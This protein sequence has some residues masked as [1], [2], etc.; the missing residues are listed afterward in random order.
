MNKKQQK[1][2]D[3]SLAILQA[4]DFPRAQQN[5][6]SALT[7]LA[8]L[9]LTPP[10]TWKDAESPM[11]GIRAILDFCR[12][13]YGKPYAENTRETFRRQTMH[14][15]VAAGLVVENPDKPERPINSPKW[16]YQIEPGALR[17]LREHYKAKTWKN[18]LADYLSKRQGLASRYAME[19]EM[20]ML[21]VIINE[22]SSIHLSSGK[23]SQLI[24]E[25]LEEFAPRFVPGCRVLYVGD[26]GEKWGYFDEEGLRALVVEVDMHGKM[27]DVVLHYP[28]RNWILLVEAVTSHGPVDGKRRSELAKLFKRC[29]AG[30]VYVTA[31]T[32]RSE[33]SRYL[34]EI[35]W[36]TEVWVAEAPTHMIHFNGVRF[37]GPYD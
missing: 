18:E 15:F 10:K 22:G 24:K 5:E 9:N 34:G 26:T 27:P 25:I 32:T 28:A 13:D 21:P 7:L 33:M 8:L 6:R 14:Q 20:L 35:S 4:L 37:L 2:L 36:E 29:S 17:F 30:V 1:L 3:E 12:S 16:C 31:F 19:R 11:I 23:H